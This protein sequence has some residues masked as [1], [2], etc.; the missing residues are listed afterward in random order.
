MEPLFPALPETLSSLTPEELA[1]VRDEFRAALRAVRDGQADTGS[2]T[3][4]QVV[5]EFQAAVLNLRAI[6]AEITGRDAGVEAFNAALAEAA[7]GVDL[8]DVTDEEAAAEEVEALAVEEP[9]EDD[10]PD[11]D[12]GAVAEE[13]EAVVAAAVPLRL[14]ASTLRVHEPV[15]SDPALAAFVASAGMPDFPEGRALTRPQL[16]EAMYHRWQALSA[17]QPGVRENVRVAR[18]RYGDLWPEEH[19]LYGTEDDAQKVNA[20]I[21]PEAMGINPE[22]GHEALVASGGL[23][24]PPT[25]LYDLAG[26]S[27]A[28]RPV[29]DSLVPF[30]AVRG[31]V[32]VAPGVSIGD[33]D[34]DAVG[35]VTAAQDETGGT[36]GAKTCW[37]VTCPSFSETL[38]AAVYACLQFGNF[39]ARAWPEWVDRFTTE[40]RS[41]HA[42]LAETA[43]LDGIAASST[44]VTRA[45]QYGATSTI[46]AGILQSAAGMRS[47]HRMDPAARFRVLLPEWLPDLLLNDLANQQFGRFDWTREGITALLRRYGVEPTFYLDGATGAGQV[48]G[49]Q[50]GGALT[51]FPTSVVGYIFPEGSFLYL[52]MGTLDLG[53]VRD[54]TLNLSNDF[55]TFMEDFENVAFVGVESQQITWT[56]CPSGAV[57]APTTA[58]TC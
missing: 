20:L 43:L 10:D 39:N 26:F 57:S 23:C 3:P 58:I 37:A 32:N 17:M 42:R 27:V 18:V 52:D 41:A 49:A 14:P 50:A 40:T 35:I 11:D 25:N 51:A 15:L 4:E 13:P 38:V 47:R 12:D 22:T 46:I 44:A 19:K 28:S 1:A 33:V 55:Q 6:E 24:A 5:E 21:G 56:V 2:R 53:I 16:V 7:E 48:F 30:A 54:S 29:R 45:A 8:G 31:G 34:G 36:T 9:A